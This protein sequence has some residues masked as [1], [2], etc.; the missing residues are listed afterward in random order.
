MAQHRTDR[1]LFASPKGDAGFRLFCFP[2]AGGRATIFREWQ[3][4]L[5]SAIEVCPVQLHPL[6]G[7]PLKASSIGLPYLVESIASDLLPYLD[8]PFAFF[9]HS[10]GALISFELTRHLRRRY[11]LLPAHLFVS[12]REAPQIFNTRPPIHALPEQEF[13]E[14]I[15]LLNGTPKEIL[16]HSEL[17][18]CV[19]PALRRGIEMC[20]TYAYLPDLPFHCPITAFGGLQDR[21]VNPFH[22]EAW[23][24][25]T[26]L[27][28]TLRMFPGDHFFIHPNRQSILEI[29][30]RELIYPL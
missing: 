21:T 27:A 5:S 6:E 12:G 24:D 18:K 15:T 11:N 2:Y 7:Q 20:E 19:L 13:L 14:E 10:L 16:A 30:L 29:L 9:G 28:F 3:D 22:L 25:Q 4:S 8:R 17:M 1:F 26:D 23:H